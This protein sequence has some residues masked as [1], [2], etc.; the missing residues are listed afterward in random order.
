MVRTSCGLGV[1]ERFLCTGEPLHRAA[2]NRVAAHDSCT[3]QL[4]GAGDMSHARTLDDVLRAQ[5][6][7]NISGMVAEAREALQEAR[8]NYHESMAIAVELQGKSRLKDVHA[9]TAELFGAC[10][11]GNSTHCLHLQ[12]ASLQV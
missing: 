6:T 7:Q 11:Q 4:K 8:T 9:A 1:C 12:R 10:W 2:P 3:A 5:A